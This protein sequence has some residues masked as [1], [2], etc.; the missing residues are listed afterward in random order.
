MKINSIT[1][2]TTLNNGLKMPWFGLGVFKSKEGEEVEQAVRWALAAGYRSI[3]TAAIYGNERGVGKAIRE[4]GVPRSEIFL[5]TKVWNEDLRAGTTRRAI[6]DSL[7]RLGTDY[8]DLY[9]IHWPVKGR[10]LQAWQAMEEI[11]HSGRVKAVG[12]SNF[13][14]H[15]LEDLLAH[16]KLIPAV[17][18][19]EFHPYLRQPELMDFCRAHGI[20]MEAWSPLMQGHVFAVP[21]I[22]QLAAKYGK[23]PAQIVLRWDLQ[24]E[25]VTIPKSVHQER[26]V[27]NKQILDFELAEDDLALLDGMNSGK[28]YGS[29][30]DDFSF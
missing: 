20:Q 24:H 17:N 23:N 28:R 8:L 6:Q 13:L 25:V 29:D 14:R 9:L 11:Y 27:E 10:Y 21:E 19:V 18:Q 15:H 7:D 22:R 1:D 4:S 12:V 5:T 3:D 26:I 30:P 16:T 2:C